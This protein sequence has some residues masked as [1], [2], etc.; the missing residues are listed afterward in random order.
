M[1]QKEIKMADSNKLSFSD[2]PILNIIFQKLQG[3]VLGQIEL[4]DPNI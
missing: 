4:I 2:P 1:K 3:L